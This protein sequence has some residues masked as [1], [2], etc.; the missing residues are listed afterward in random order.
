MV[1]LQAVNIG[2]VRQERFKRWN[3]SIPFSTPLSWMTSHFA[4]FPAWGCSPE[5]E[6]GPC[7]ARVQVLRHLQGWAIGMKSRKEKRGYDSPSPIGASVCCNQ[8]RLS[9]VGKDYAFSRR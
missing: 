1:F 2:R 5:Q 6:Q 7:F 3:S 8:G 4:L 9:F